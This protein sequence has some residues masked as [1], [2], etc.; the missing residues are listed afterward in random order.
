[1]DADDEVWPPPPERQSEQIET[2]VLQE[3]KLDTI[4]VMWVVTVGSFAFRLFGLSSV[5]AIGGIASFCLA[6]VLL[7]SRDKAAVNHGIARVIL[8]MVLYGFFSI[9]E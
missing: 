9:R 7:G 5:S 1:M 4:V 8:S 3:P 2:K 6:L